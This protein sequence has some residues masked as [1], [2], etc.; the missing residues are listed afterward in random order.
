MKFSL[1]MTGL[2]LSGLVQVGAAKPKEQTVDF[3]KK[4]R[5]VIVYQ[6]DGKFCGWPANEGVWSWGD[7]ILLG[8]ELRRY[9]KSTTTHSADYSQPGSCPLVRSRDGGVTWELE[10]GEWFDRPEFIGDSEKNDPA[11]KS[12]VALTE[13]LDFTAPGFA[14]KLRGTLYYYSYDR[15]KSWIGPVKLTAE[16]RELS[17]MSRTD[18]IV[19]GRRECLVFSAAL[20]SNQESGVSLM[21]KTVDGGMTWQLVSFLTE[22]PPLDVKHA[23]SIMPSTVKLADGTLVTAVRERREKKKWIDILASTDGGKTWEKIA[24]PSLM[25]WNP[26]SLILLQDGRLCLTYCD[27]RKPY[28]VRAVL[29]ADGGKTWGDPLILRNDATTWDIGYVRSV[30]R[31]DG[32]VVTMYY[33]ST[34]QNPQQHIA[35]TIWMPENGRQ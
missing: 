29:S 14:M 22:E 28:S 27:R 30:Q 6:E 20:K 32:K 1:V 18:Y 13:P 24:T 11:Q 19:T 21:L 8:F 2:L 26:P 10:P 5:N 7:E 35:G 31:T 33:Y 23:F 16:G 3:T 25:A 15:G 17:L 12:A 9:R 34:E 4:V